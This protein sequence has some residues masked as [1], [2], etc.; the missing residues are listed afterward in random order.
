[1]KVPK[2]IGTF[3]VASN[4]AVHGVIHESTMTEVSLGVPDILVE[5]QDVGN[6]CLE[7]WCVETCFS[8]SREQA[9]LK[10]QRFADRSTHGIVAATLID[11]TESIRYSPPSDTSETAISLAKKT[12]VTPPQRWH[13]KARQNRNR[14]SDSVVVH[15]H[16]WVS[17]LTLT[18][19][20]WLCEPGP[21]KKLDVKDRD[22]ECYAHG[23]SHF[24]PSCSI[25]L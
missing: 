10:L 12:T 21:N 24:P 18:I 14:Y 25:D 22:P 8:Q 6:I 23:V 7:L 11:I 13:S 9:I 20:T 1:M 17:S 4:D 2:S 5:F 3:A 16:T 15:Q 19:T